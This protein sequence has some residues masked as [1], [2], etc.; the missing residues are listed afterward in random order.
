M[1]G[2]EAADSEAT[3]V[4]TLGN[5]TGLGEGVLDVMTEQAD[6]LCD[7]QSPE[8]VSIA[9]STWDVAVSVA[10]PTGGSLEAFKE[11]SRQAMKTMC[12]KF[13]GVA[14]YLRKRMESP[15]QKKQFFNKLVDMFPLSEAVDYN[16]CASLPVV[17]ASML[18]SVLPRKLHI[19][20]LSFSDICS[21]K[22]DPE[23]ETAMLL[24]DEYLSDGFLTSGDALI[25]IQNDMLTEEA[26]ALEL[27]APWTSGRAGDTLVPHS[28]GYVKGRARTA[29]LFA[30][31]SMVIDEEVNLREAFPWCV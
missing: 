31:L 8:N 13:G 9:P 17:E 4:L 21:V 10:G 3:V 5:L 24:L 26:A 15:E 20:M 29:T 18:S 11:T 28:V 6:H 12:G 23:S 22:N 14:Q 27:K 1:A 16:T 19:T 2:S 30:Y 7:D 25:L